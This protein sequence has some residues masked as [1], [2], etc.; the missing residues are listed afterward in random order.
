MPGVRSCNLKRELMCRTL[1]FAHNDYDGDKAE[2]NEQQLGHICGSI[3]FGIKQEI[4]PIRTELII[5]PVN[6]TPIS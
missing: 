5:E 1:L 6:N 4:E 3:S 2:M